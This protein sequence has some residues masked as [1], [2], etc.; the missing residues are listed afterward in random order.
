MRVI[1]FLFSIFLCFLMLISNIACD[2][3]RTQ[4]S[5]KT[6]EADKSS[7]EY[8]KSED[9]VFSSA[10]FEGIA[11]VAK[12]E[13]KDNFYFIDK[14]GEIIFKIPNKNKQNNAVSQS[15]R[16]KSFSG[17]SNGKTLQDGVLYERTGKSILPK[18]VGATDFVTI[19][20]GSYI[21]ALNIISDYSSATM[22]MG[23]LNTKLEWVIPLSEENYKRYQE[24][25]DWFLEDLDSETIIYYTPQITNLSSWSGFVDGN[26]AVL[27]I[28]PETKERFLSVIDE[29]EAFAFDPVKITLPQGVVGTSVYFDG[30][31]IIVAARTNTSFGTEAN[32][33]YLLSYNK[34]GEKTSELSTSSFDAETVTPLY[35]EGVIVFE[36]KHGQYSAYYRDSEVVYYNYE[37]KKMF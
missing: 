21:I 12:R 15:A 24:D 10:Y 27:M 25:D 33:I 14:N 11:M 17:F 34:R 36:L 19:I 28:N 6:D 37:L 16:C 30:E 22:Q 8:I 29:K 20:R 2:I 3:Q 1:K 32:P 18:D 13:D 31:H 4:G 9:I 23:I 35:N 5:I 7:G 26:A